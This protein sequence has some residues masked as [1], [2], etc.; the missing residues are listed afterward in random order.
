MGDARLGCC[1][2]RNLSGIKVDTVAEYGFGRE[3]ATCFINVSVVMRSHE[4]MVHFLDFFAILGEMS[5]KIGVETSGQFGGVA[6]EF[7][8]TSDCETRTECIF[9]PP[10]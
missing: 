8:R 7:F 5:L 1:D 9:E 6:H 3:E 2:R 10:V 4:K